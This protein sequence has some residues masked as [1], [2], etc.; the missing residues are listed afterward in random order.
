M[1]VS[2]L[3]PRSRS[4][5]SSAAFRRNGR[6]D[7]RRFA[8]GGGLARQREIR[9][10]P[11]GAGRNDLQSEKPRP[12]GGSIRI[13]PLQGRGEPFIGLRLACPIESSA[14]PEC[15]QG[16]RQLVTNA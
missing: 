9:S 14:A 8:T 3:L 15:R 10:M 7:G 11:S 13:V 5:I 12:A 1:A 6:D 2:I 16:L 4:E